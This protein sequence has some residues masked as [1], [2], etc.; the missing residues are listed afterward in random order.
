M[1]HVVDAKGET[2]E[3][4]EGQASGWGLNEGSLRELFSFYHEGQ[5]NPTKLY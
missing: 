4:L 1:R 3:A 2:L 5:L